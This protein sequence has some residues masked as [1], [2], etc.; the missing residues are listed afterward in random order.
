MLPQLSDLPLQLSN[1]LA[2]GICLLF[3]RLKSRFHL[4]RVGVLRTQLVD[5]SQCTGRHTNDLV[6][7]IFFFRTFL[8]S[9]LDIDLGVALRALRANAQY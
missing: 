2:L 1:F 3:E 8:D 4:K 7:L 9:S 6:E 5:S